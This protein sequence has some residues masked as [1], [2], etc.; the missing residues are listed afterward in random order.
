MLY[1]NDSERPL[2]IQMA[3]SETNISTCNMQEIIYVEN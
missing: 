1:S 3:V 2:E